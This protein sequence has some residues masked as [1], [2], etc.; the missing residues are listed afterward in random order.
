M[1][2]KVFTFIDN[3]QLLKKNKTILIGVSGGPDSMALLHFLNEWKE[4]WN[5]SVKIGRAHV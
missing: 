3:H 4:R 1:N 2:E 5:V